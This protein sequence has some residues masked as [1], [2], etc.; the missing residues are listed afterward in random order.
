MRQPGQINGIHGGCECP[1]ANWRVVD[2][3][4]N[5]SAFNGYHRTWSDYS[6]VLCMK[7]WHTWRTKARYVAGL[8]DQSEAERRKWHGTREIVA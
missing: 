2:R 8:P 5:Y 1:R 6:R 7:C 3:N 4:C